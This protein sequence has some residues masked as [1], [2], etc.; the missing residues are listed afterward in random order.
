MPPTTAKYPLVHYHG[1]T[2]HEDGQHSVTLSVRAVR[3]EYFL[4][5]D[6][7]NTVEYLCRNVSARKALNFAKSRASRIL[8]TDAIAATITS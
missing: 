4:T 1:H 7:C 2:V 6:Q 5:P 8:R 3:Y